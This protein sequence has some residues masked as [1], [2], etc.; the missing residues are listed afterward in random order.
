MLNHLQLEG[1]LLQ[2]TVEYDEE[3]EECIPGNLEDAVKDLGHDEQDYEG[4]M[5]NVSCCITDLHTL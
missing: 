4:Y 2:E 5:G 1:R 3:G